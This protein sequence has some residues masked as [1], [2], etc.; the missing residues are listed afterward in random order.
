MQFIISEI[1]PL[2]TCIQTP[3]SEVTCMQTKFTGVNF[4][5]IYNCN[6]WK[7]IEDKTKRIKERLKNEYLLSGNCAFPATTVRRFLF[8]LIQVREVPQNLPDHFMFH[9]H[10]QRLRRNQTDNI[11]GCTFAGCYK[12][13]NSAFV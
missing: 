12:A 13:D 7:K 9:L 11:R 1:K 2:A 5:C 6:K 4:V 3:G 10:T 8:T